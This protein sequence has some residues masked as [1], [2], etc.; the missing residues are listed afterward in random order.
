MVVLC[1]LLENSHWQS[2]ADSIRADPTEIQKSL[3]RMM[4]EALLLG[5][6]ILEYHS[7]SPPIMGAIRDMVQRFS[8]NKTLTRHLKNVEC[9]QCWYFDPRFVLFEFI[10]DGFL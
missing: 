1:C 10:L 5:C 4:W 9:S 3:P 2:V 6:F 7:S 8:G